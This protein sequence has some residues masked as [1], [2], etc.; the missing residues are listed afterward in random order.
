ME[1]RQNKPFKISLFLATACAPATQS[2]GDFRI[3]H[4]FA[5]IP[6]G[7]LSRVHIRPVNYEDWDDERDTTLPSPAPPNESR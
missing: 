7:L 2:D 1:A 6:F 5:T 3:C 4:A